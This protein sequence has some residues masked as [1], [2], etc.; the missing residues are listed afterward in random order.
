MLE[1]PQTRANVLA[2]FLND[3]ARGGCLAMCYIYVLTNGA[4]DTKTMIDWVLELREAGV[5]G[6]DC[7]VNDFKKVARFVKEKLGR[8]IPCQLEW[9]KIDSIWG[10]G[11]LVI[12]KWK[13]QDNKTGHWVVMKDKKIIFNSLEKSHNVD[14]GDIVEARRII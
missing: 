14:V 13:A 10:S 8:E 7:Y 1:C 9:V 11:G 3:I 5:L 6:A 12:T 4:I 2:H